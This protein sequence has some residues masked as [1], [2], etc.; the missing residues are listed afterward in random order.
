MLRFAILVFIA[1]GSFVASAQQPP[2]DVVPDVAPPYY[3]VRFE[4]SKESGELRFPVKYTVWIPPNTKRLRGVVVHQHGCGEGS[5]K[6][7]LTGAFDLHWQALAKKHQCALLAPSYEQPQ[8]AECQ[9]WCDPR[10]G[11]DEA[12]RKGLDELGNQSGHPELGEV[13]WA[14]WG[15]S[16]G[17]HW[18]GSMVMLHPER[19]V[20]AWLRSGVPLF[21]PNP[22]RL[23]IKPHILPEAALSVPMM[24]NPGTKEGVTVKDGRFAKVWPANQAFFEEVRGN[25]GLIG[26]AVDPLTAHECGNQRYM[27]IPWLDACLEARLPESTGDSLRPMPKNDVWLATV[28]ETQA[29]EKADFRG[30]M[31]RAIWLPNSDIARRWTAYV[32]DTQVPDA[33]RPPSPTDVRTNGNTLTWQCEADVESG[34]A[35]FIIERDGKRI[36]TVPEDNKNRFG[37]PIFQGLQYSDTPLQPLRQMQ[38]TDT[39]TDGTKTPRYRV[40]AVNTVGLES[41][42]SK[43]SE[44]S[45]RLLDV[46]KIWD[47]GK[48]N[49]FTDLIRFGDRWFCVFREADSHV[50]PD[51]SIRVITSRDGD[52]W[53]SAARIQSDSGD[54][55]DPKITKTPDGR[56][57]IIAAEA[58][59]VGDQNRHQTLLWTSTDGRQWKEPIEI[60]ERYNWLWRVSWQEDRAF[61]FG[62]FTLAKT[63]GLVLF[64]GDER[65]QFNPVAPETA[66][67]GSYPNETSIVFLPDRTALCLLRQDGEP[68]TGFLGLGSPPDYARWQWRPLNSR[69]GGPHLIRLPDGRLLAAVRL[70]DGKTRTSLCWLDKETA[71][72]SEALTLP[73]GGDTSY[74]GLAWHNGE[75]WVSYYSGHEATPNRAKTSI[76]LARVAIE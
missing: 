60:G 3:R 53:E 20:A 27:A 34:L 44:P 52:R 23:E 32:N 28:L 13:P 4:A 63:R 12:F 67:P 47:K 50:S 10:N 22:E 66:I 40:I 30:E 37:R 19:V 29:V 64:K 56:L 8:G 75:L 35:R 59:K 49:A 9:L 41:R 68:K 5:C 45:M 69:I 25:G 57:M 65:L 61:G 14:L 17:G 16:G 1:S 62:Y 55:R 51:G 74:A 18:C 11:S 24:C 6:S 15:H 26:I 76:Y 72:L 21:K 36:A 71:T 42:P 31:N 39:S 58:L 48:H 46:R 70:Y 2:Y 38:F 7:G 54:L 73:S 43:R 33:S